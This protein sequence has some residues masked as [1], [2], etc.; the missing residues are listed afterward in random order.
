M[1]LTPHR[2]A[3]APSYLHDEPGAQRAERH[4]FDPYEQTSARI[5]AL[6]KIGHPA[7]KIELLILGGT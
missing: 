7:E 6:E 5:R 3:D 1:H 4:A 2:C